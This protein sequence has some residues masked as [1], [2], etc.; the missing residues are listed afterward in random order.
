MPPLMIQHCDRCRQ[1]IPYPP[2]KL[3]VAWE[4]PAKVEVAKKEFASGKLV[5]SA[6][7]VVLYQKCCATCALTFLNDPAVQVSRDRQSPLEQRFE[8][9][10]LLKDGGN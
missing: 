6:E 4:D 1:P 3:P 5:K 8:A 9:V 7:L 10:F 2:I